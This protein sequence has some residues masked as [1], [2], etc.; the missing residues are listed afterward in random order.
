MSK[1]PRAVAA[2]AAIFLV[3]AAPVAAQYE[4]TTTTTT[5]PPPAREEVSSNKE[6]TDPGGVVTMGGGSDQPLAEQGA[7]VTV[8][9]AP[10]NSGVVIQ[11]VVTLLRDESGN[12]TSVDVTVPEDT[13]TGLYFIEIVVDV[14]GG[15]FRVLI[16]PIVVRPAAEADPEAAGFSSATFESRGE[17]GT[18]YWTGQSTST[19]SPKL[20]AIQASVTSPVDEAAIVR[21]VVENDA[22]VTV[23]DG[24]L[25][26]ST[27][28]LETIAETSD[29]TRPLVAALAVGLAG[30]GLVLLRRRTPARKVIR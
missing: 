12:V 25:L 27:S 5:A 10:A 3:G 22:D 30:G 11:P 18:D 20:Q 13:P 7:T 4:P 28:A 24:E 14:P 29:D 1:L 16:A 6:Q 9:L 23:I 17:P 26:V 19:P 21:A 15:G 8:N 2:A